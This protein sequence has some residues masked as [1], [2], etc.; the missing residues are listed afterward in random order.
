M[1]QH[2]PRHKVNETQPKK[3]GLIVHS[4]HHSYTGVIPGPAQAKMSDLISK[5]TKAKRIGVWLVI[6]CL[7][8][9]CKVLSSSLSTEK[10]KQSFISSPTFSPKSGN[11]MW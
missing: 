7:S 5:I 4:C 8:G 1:A 2:Q 3:R 6:E 9:K 11:Y 10:K